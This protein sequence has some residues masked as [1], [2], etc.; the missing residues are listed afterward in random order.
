MLTHI[1]R[2]DAIRSLP[3]LLPS[4]L[5]FPV[6]Y[7]TT[8]AGAA[9]NYWVWG[10]WLAL[11][12]YFST[13]RQRASGLDLGLPISARRLWLAHS[14]A[15]GLGGAAILALTMSFE[16]LVGQIGDVPGAAAQLFDGALRLGA[17]LVIA[18]VL[19][20]RREPALAR[21]TPSNFNDWYKFAVMF[22][23]GPIIVLLL[24]GVWVAVLLGLALGLGVRTWRSLPPAFTLGPM[25]YPEPPAEPAPLHRHSVSH[26]WTHCLSFP[27][28]RLFQPFR[29]V[30]MWP[31][32]LVLLGVQL[33]GMRIAPLVDIR[34]LL[35]F[36]VLG[37]LMAPVA[38]SLHQ[39]AMLDPLP[40]SR[41]FLFAAMTLPPMA[42]LVLGFGLG[43]VLK[44]SF[45]GVYAI[46]GLLIGA[47]GLVLVALFLEALQAFAGGL[48]SLWIFQV[49]LITAWTSGTL[50]H[51]VV[52]RG[53]IGVNAPEDFA[54]ALGRQL[55]TVLP[56]GQAALGLLA[57]LLLGG[58]Y[59]LAEV[60]FRRF[61]VPPQRG[62]PGDP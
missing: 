15:L 56:G 61:E 37:C 60:R 52:E 48:A 14:L 45:D 39:L 6:L 12:V 33:S 32:L 3:L 31:F 40:L 10:H 38:M 13:E 53:W 59:A 35:G 17:S 5:Y 26:S 21:L 30:G 22:G 34:F 2:D 29:F 28:T 62:D 19:L 36:V 42:A 7:Y 9:G 16:A 44:G 55:S 41:R 47:L 27:R 1:R 57:V 4:Y 8:M 23:V 54:Q 20:Q 24:D 58:A 43:T 18:V 11:T 49:F 50:F 25:A 46:F 51:L